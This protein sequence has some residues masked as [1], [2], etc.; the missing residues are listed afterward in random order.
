V[1]RRPTLLVA[2][3]AAAGV[4]VAVVVALTRSPAT[5]HVGASG[6][7]ERDADVRVARTKLGPILVDA[8][9]HTLYLFLK[10]RHGRSACYEACAQI[11]SPALASGSPLAGADV[12]KAK[13]TTTRRRDHTRQLVYNGHPLYALDADTRPGEIEGEGFLGTW[14]VVSP[15]GH[16]VAEPGTSSPGGY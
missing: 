1:T 12:A 2:A 5:S 15:A 13:L 8:R 10:D 16:S 14:F 4:A 9:G 7:G 3:I 11:W 6:S